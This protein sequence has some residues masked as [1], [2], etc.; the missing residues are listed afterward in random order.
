MK[1]SVPKLYKKYQTSKFSRVLGVGGETHQILGTILLE[2]DIEN[3]TFPQKFH[4]FRQLQHPVILGDDFLSKYSG[5]ID[6]GKRKLSLKDDTIHVNSFTKTVS[7][8]VRTT[9]KVTLPPG[10]ETALPVKISRPYEGSMLLEPV[11]SFSKAVPV[12]MAKSVIKPNKARSFCKIL[13]P[14]D[15]VLTLHAGKIIGSATPI[16]DIDI[17]LEITD[18]TQSINTTSVKQDLNTEHTTKPT[19]SKEEC[20]EIAK[21]LGI[22]TDNKNLTSNQKEQLLELIGRNRPVFAKDPAQLGCAKGFT[23]K[24]DTGDAKPHAQQPYRKSPKMAAIEEENVQEMLQN[25]IIQHSSSLWQSPVVLVKKKTGEFRFAVDYRKANN[26]TKPESYPVPRLESILDTIAVSNAKYFST[27]DLASGFWQIPMDPNSKHKTAFA[28]QSGKYEF[29]RMP[30]GLINAPTTYQRM[31][32]QV[33]QGLNWKILLV[34]MDDI[35]IFSSTFEEH[36]SHL[37]QVFRRLSEFNLTLKPSKCTFA[38]ERVLYL[39]HIISEKGVEINH[40]K[41]AV[42]ESFPAPKNVK[43]VREFLGMCNFYRKFIKGFSQIAAPM[44]AL[45]KADVEF[46]WTEERNLAFEKLKHAL[47]N[48]PVLAHPNMEKKFIVTTDAST[49]GIGYI[50]SQEDDNG[51]EHPI[52]YGGRSLRKHEKNYPITELECLAVVE[53]VKQFHI[54]LADKTFEIYTDHKALTGLINTK[55]EKGRLNRWAQFLMS[56]KKEIHYREG[57]KMANADALSRREYPEPKEEDI[58]DIV[59]E[60]VVLSLEPTQNFVDTSKTYHEITFEYENDTPEVNFLTTT[61]K[62]EPNISTLSDSNIANDQ[63]NDPDFKYIYAYLKNNTLPNTTEL[64]RRVL[65]E[66]EYYDLDN[67]ILYH[68]HTNRAK[69]L[70]KYQRTTKQLAVPQQLRPEILHAYHDSLLGGG[71]QGYERTLESIRLKYYWPRMPTIIQDYINSCDICQKSKRKYGR[72]KAPLTN[73]PI[74]DRFDRWHMDFIGPINPPG[75]DGSKHL[76]VMVDSFSRWCEAI[77]TKTQEAT[78][79][80]DTIYANIICRYG[81]PRKLVSDRGKNFLSKVIKNL[82]ELFNIKRHHTSSYHPQTN[83]ACERLNSYIETQLKAYVAKNPGTWNRFIPGIMMNY[84]KTP[85][86]QSTGYSPFF[87]LFGSEMNC[88]ID[89]SLLQE[90]SVPKEIK[91]YVQ[92]LID[93]N[94]QSNSIAKSNIEQSQIKNKKFYDKNTK[95][96][97]F[98]VGDEVLLQQNHKKAGIAQKMHRANQEDV[99]YISDTGDNYTFDITNKKTNKKRKGRVNTNRLR[100]YINPNDSL[101]PR[102]Q[103]DEPQREN[104]QQGQNNDLIPEDDELPQI[105]KILKGSRSNGKTYYRV[106]FQDKKRRPEWRLATDI[107]PKM[108]QDFHIH[109]TLSGRSKKK[110]RPTT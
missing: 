74:D 73:M 55:P 33:L 32:T 79:V 67:G 14:T 106:Q 71:H 49:T 84:R 91:E 61:P 34:Y 63:A 54:Y 38:A 28:T 20:I 39:G 25:D 82:S 58:P 77:P 29:N 76:L 11:S 2:F 12:L 4:V 102:P 43:K 10:C 46:Q 107:P 21:D 3:T 50:L 110:R 104:P 89:T 45:L 78:E 23:H 105:K 5:K 31:M 94:L 7:S 27:L 69:K 95:V 72:H 52:I 47:A 85:A 26:C 103:E 44:Y 19:L 88:P 41:V 13:N 90:K 99:F 56:Y 98:K 65:V 57:K 8:L 100:H 96:P 97:S 83:S 109:K 59:D 92:K 60:K 22:K 80:A 108:V 64:M 15:E 35:I 9:C 42:I 1:F 40:S 36:M 86:M 81:A 93:T 51:Q 70:P 17:S 18:E 66:C 87:L 6:I 101:T 53:G 37:E 75:T 68:L 24:I 62:F 48:T 16:E 30:F